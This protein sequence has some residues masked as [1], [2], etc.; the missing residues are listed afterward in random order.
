[1]IQR[2]QTIY[3]L[4][5]AILMGI[6]MFCPVGTIVTGEKE[7]SEF[8]NLYIALGD[9]VKDYSPWALFVLLL[10]VAVLSVVSIFLFKKRMVQI[11]LSIFNIV[12]LIGYYITL[13]VFALTMP[14]E[15]TSFI[16]SWV[17]CLPFVSI[18][19]TWL[20]IR[21][22]GADEALVRSYERLR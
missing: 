1:M 21:A 11:R 17:V 4:V 12:L 14:A 19:L 3:L 2:I 20:A 22:I 15:G 18:V 9:G 16:P 5:V 8:T 13:M 6:C 7:F 10:I